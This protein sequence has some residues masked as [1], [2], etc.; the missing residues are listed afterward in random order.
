MKPSHRIRGGF[1]QEFYQKSDGKYHCDDGPAIVGYH[2]YKDNENNIIKY[3]KWYRNGKLHRDNGPAIIN[4]TEL[5]TVVFE[6]WFKNGKPHRD[7]GPA[8]ISYK[9]DSL[10]NYY[11][12][13]EEKW[14]KNGKVHRIDGPAVTCYTVS[15]STGMICKQKEEYFYQGSYFLGF[16]IKFATP[17]NI[18]GYKNGH[19]FYERRALAYSSDTYNYFKLMDIDHSNKNI[20]IDG[21]VWYPNGDPKFIKYALRSSEGVVLTILEIKYFGR[22]RIQSIEWMQGE[23]TIHRTSGPAI[24]KFDEKGN[25]TRCEFWINGINVDSLFEVI[26]NYDIPMID[27]FHLWTD[28]QKFLVKMHIDDEQILQLFNQIMTLGPINLVNN[29]GWFD[30]VPTL[31]DEVYYGRSLV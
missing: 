28:E 26:V 27:K 23:Y 9:N 21:Q 16:P 10:H 4:Y 7:N 2:V 29:D 5:G 11:Y 1:F 17:F 15:K 19:K 8:E 12:I 6:K 3:E 22:G 25:I 13:S 14:Y 31:S 20:I 18:I 24:I 30:T